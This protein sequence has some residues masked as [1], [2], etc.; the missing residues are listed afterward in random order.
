MESKD[1]V[2]LLAIPAILV[3][4]VFYISNPSITGA[5][6]AEQNQNNIIGTY[7]ISPSFKAKFS[8]DL[9]D[10]L[11]IKNS[12]DEIIKCA[13][14]NDIQS[15]TAS[16]NS[17]DFEWMLG[18]D[19]A[20]EKVLY[21][22]A[23]FYQD[24]FD[25]A[26]NDCVC[27]KNMDISKDEIMKYNLPKKEFRLAV[28]QDIPTNKVNIKFVKPKIDL[29]YDIKING[30]SIWYPSLYIIS[31]ADDKLIGVNM[32]FTDELSGERRAL[33]PLNELVL[34]K[35]EVNGI[36]SVDFV[37]QEGNSLIYPNNDIKKLSNIRAC[38]LKP[39]N[40]YKFCVKK[41]NFKIMAYDNADGLI[42]E[43]PL[44]IKFA[45]YIPDN[46][47]EPLKGLEVF[48]MPKAEKSVLIKWEKSSAKDIAKYKIYSTQQSGLLE[49]PTE[50]L[51]KDSN[52]FVHEIDVSAT[53]IIELEDS[54]IPND[55]EFDYQ[56]KKCIFKT[57][58]GAKTF[59]GSNKLYY[60]KKSNAY[61]Y[62]LNVPEDKAYDFGATAIDR[63]GNE[64]N[65][66]E[67]KQKIPVIKGIKSIDDLPPDSSMQISAN[68][69][70]QSNHIL[71]NLLTS[72]TKNIDESKLEEKDFNGY[73]VYYKKYNKFTTMEEELITSDKLR[74]SKLNELKS[75]Q[76]I[77]SKQNLIKVDISSENP[78]KD[79]IFFFA[80]ILTD[81]NGNPKEDQ[82]KVKE[83]GA[84]P[85]KVVV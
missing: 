10:Y 16:A 50:E 85:V 48:D 8:Y 46:P 49:R 76:V 30:R 13:Q 36:K 59:I 3:T 18:C 66:I 79:N 53:Q 6:T 33:G 4:L 47:P 26:D 83:L 43:R 22:L 81:I 9:Q 64:I 35:N 28:S 27:R 62:R 11:K 17:N 19:N 7:S 72:T 20:Q 60:S 52:V 15:C 37:K 32:F 14:Q 70:E 82:F 74:D 40:I 31:Y 67:Q 57:K 65:N 41:K 24:C 39:K 68:Y 78:Q 44:A 73:K 69:D 1:L 84:V 25:S 42:K 56:N 54:I 23:E 2:L 38:N 80:I 51:K 77:E 5:A 29:S 58:D 61:F 12:F 71:F 63:N 55:C 21:D 75:A 45:S 34:Y